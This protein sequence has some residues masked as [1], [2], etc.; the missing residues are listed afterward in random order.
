RAGWRPARPRAPPT[1][2]EGAWELHLP[3]RIDPASGADGSGGPSGPGGDFSV[4]ALTRTRTA[5]SKR[6]GLLLLLVAVVVSSLA[7]S[8]TAIALGSRA[9]LASS[10]R[11]V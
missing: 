4:T 8:A 7:A 10:R 3:P 1:P 9:D 5:S 6:R 11:R 2:G